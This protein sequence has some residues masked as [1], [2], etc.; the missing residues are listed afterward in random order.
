MEDL[1]ERRFALILTPESPFPIPEIA[2]ALAA[3]LHW[4]LTDAIVRT[5]YGR[6]ILA[7][8]L[9]EELSRTLRDRLAEIGVAAEI[10]DES[11]WRVAP[12]GYQAVALEF[13]PDVML[14]RLQNDQELVIPKQDVFALDAYGLRPEETGAVPKGDLSP[15]APKVPLESHGEIVL[16]SAGRK[17]LEMLKA[18][19]HPDM[20]LRLTIYCAEPFGALHIR[21]DRFDYESLGARRRLHSLDN[22]LALLELLLDEFPDV[23]NR[24]TVEAFLR[25]LD[26]S[27]I[28]R[29]KREEVENF[30]RWVLYWIQ[31][32]R[33]ESPPGSP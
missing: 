17:L 7:E 27:A 21:K 24:E 11:R 8:G 12:R 3:A 22:Y 33:E 1:E 9:D 25:D 30:H 29:W 19:E 4:P 16:T 15:R 18:H 6:G 10:V 5:R 32:T 28:F 20:E 26:P 31:A 14:A 2:K 23:W 13:L